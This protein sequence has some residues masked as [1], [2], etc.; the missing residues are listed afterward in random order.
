MQLLK[1]SPPADLLER[2]LGHIAMHPGHSSQE[3]GRET[4]SLG[5]AMHRHPARVDE[6]ESFIKFPLPHLLLAALASPYP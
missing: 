3:P 2:V 1:T 4:D 6:I 5:C